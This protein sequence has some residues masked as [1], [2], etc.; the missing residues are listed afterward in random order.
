L[1]RILFYEDIRFT[2]YATAAGVVIGTAIS[3]TIRKRKRSS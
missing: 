1:V 3:L 2:I